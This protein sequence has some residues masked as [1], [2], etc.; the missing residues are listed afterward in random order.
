MKKRENITKFRILTLRAELK[1]LNADSQVWMKEPQRLF[2]F[3][4]RMWSHEFSFRLNILMLK[5]EST[6]HL[7]DHIDCGENCS[8]SDHSGSLASSSDIQLLETYFSSATAMSWKP[9]AVM[10][11]L[12]HITVLRVGGKRKEKYK[13]NKNHQINL[14][15]NLAYWNST[16][17]NIQNCRRQH[18][19]NLSLVIH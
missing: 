18:F 13:L 10:L 12:S 15:W 14:K 4:W 11:F 16:L 6:Q 9:C 8:C 1:D 7:Q 5:I 17:L 2:P 19:K 3:F